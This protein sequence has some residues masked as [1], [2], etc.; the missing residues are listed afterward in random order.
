M[1]KWIIPIFQSTLLYSSLSAYAISWFGKFI[2]FCA[3]PFDPWD[4]FMG[5]MFVLQYQNLKGL[6]ALKKVLF[7]LH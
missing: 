3:E 1:K 6:V 5:N 7:I 2:Y 4:P